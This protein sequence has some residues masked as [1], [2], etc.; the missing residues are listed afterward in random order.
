LG[1]SEAAINTMWFLVGP[2]PPLRNYDTLSMKQW[3]GMIIDREKPVTVC[4]P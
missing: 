2:V 1:Q 3:R 4:P